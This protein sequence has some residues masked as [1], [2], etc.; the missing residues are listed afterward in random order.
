MAT[1]LQKAGARILAVYDD[2]PNRAASLAR[3]YPGARVAASFDG[4]LE[5]G[6]IEL[7]VTAAIPARRADLMVAAVKRG[8][9]VLC[10]KPLC[11]DLIHLG[12]IE[13]AVRQYHGRI[14]VFYAESLLFPAMTR[15]L[16]LVGKGAIGEVRLL[17]GS[18]PHKLRRTDRPPW[19]FDPRLSGGILCDI[20]S[21][22]ADQFLRFTR[23]R[24]VRVVH[25]RSGGPGKS[26]CEGW[27]NWG[28]MTLEADN[29]AVGHFRVDWLYPEHG[30]MWGD[31]RVSVVGTQGT[32][33]VRN[34]FSRHGKPGGNTLVVLSEQGICQ[35]ECEPG[36]VQFFEQVVAD[37][38]AGTE[39]AI[40]F[41]HVIRTSRISLEAQ[42]IAKRRRA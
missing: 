19:F 3:F 5:D 30:E 15:A 24:D 20:G 37:L 9:H 14:F 12:R 23:A 28:A 17:Q 35:E 41:E 10:T 29:G 33:E 36:C 38:A 26:E 6:E 8:K 22:Q 42:E 27:E 1:G 2:N 25:A 11:T 31:P 13:E 21:H 7:V 16:E 39:S 40:T 32:I 18:S 34:L 4:I